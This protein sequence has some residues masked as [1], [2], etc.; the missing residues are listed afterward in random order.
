MPWGCLDFFFTDFH[1]PPS[2]ACRDTAPDI[3]RPPYL[4]TINLSSRP[5]LGSEPHEGPHTSPRT[6]LRRRGGFLF[7]RG[8]CEHTRVLSARSKGNQGKAGCRKGDCM[9]LH[10]LLPPAEV[11]S[12]CSTPQRVAQP[13]AKRAFGAIAAKRGRTS[14]LLLNLLL[15]FLPFSGTSYLGAACNTDF[16]EVPL[17]GPRLNLCRQ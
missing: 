6:S 3:P 16:Y 8:I 9:A 4:W 12:V 17:G 7:I 2:S 11:L 10:P 14:K 1:F 5:V 15:N 13:A